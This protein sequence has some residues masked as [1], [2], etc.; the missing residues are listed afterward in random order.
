MAAYHA[1]TRALALHKD[2]IHTH[3]VEEGTPA[4]I[5]ED[6][7]AVFHQFNS[8]LIDSKLKWINNK[9]LRA[10]E[11][12]AEGHITVEHVP[13]KSNYADVM[14]KAAIPISEWIDFRKAYMGE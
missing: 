4:R 7:Q 1:I 8:P 3:V 11:L 9:Y 13:S 12:T 14:T 5:F 10:L 6:N 2:L